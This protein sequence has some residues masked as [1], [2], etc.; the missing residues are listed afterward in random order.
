M[1]GT[2][3]FDCVV[4]A[5]AGIKF[6]LKEPLSN[7][8]DI[9]FS[10]LSDTPPAHFYV[11]NL[12]FIECANVL[13]KHV[14][15]FDYPV[16]LARQNIADLIALPLRSIMMEDMAEDALILATR[17]NCSVY[18]AAYVVLAQQLSLPLVTAD[19]KLLRVISKAD[20]DIRFL[21]DWPEL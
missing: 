18:D 6:F 20:F 11:P 4:D 13:W 3:S 12:F 14:K 2:S 19:A 10:H 17:Y 1:T 5:S 9:L 15:R 7:R 21:G 16:D 8:A